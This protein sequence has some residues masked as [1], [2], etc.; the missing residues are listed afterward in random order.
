MKNSKRLYSILPI[1]LIIIMVPYFWQVVYAQG[2]QGAI[3]YPID[4]FSMG[5]GASVVPQSISETSST[6]VEGDLSPI[7]SA[8][9][10][11][12][13]SNQDLSTGNVYISSYTVIDALGSE[14]QN[15]YPEDTIWIAVTVVDERRSQNEI[16]AI[17]GENIGNYVQSRIVNGAFSSVVPGNIT[18]KLRAPVNGKLSFT[19]IFQDTVYRGGAPVFKFDIIQ[20]DGSNQSS[21]PTVTLE[22]PIAQ[23]NDVENE[24]GTIV[25]RSITASTATVKNGDSFT[26]TSTISNTGGSVVKDLAATVSSDSAFALQTT[27]AIKYIGDFANGT[28]ETLVF[29]FD[30]V[31]GTES[32]IYSIE[33]SF[34]GTSEGSALSC[35]QSIDIHVVA[36]ERFSITDITAPD[37]LMVGQEDFVS[38]TVVNMGKSAIYNVTVTMFAENTSNT[39]QTKYIGNIESGTENK[40]EF[41]IVP[42]EAGAFKGEFTVTYENNEGQEESI[43]ETVSMTV[44][45]AATAGAQDYANMVPEASED[46]NEINVWMVVSIVLIIVLI[47]VVLLQ[48]VHYR[49]R[50]L[51]ILLEEDD[52]G[53]DSIR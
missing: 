36:E 51:K 2:Y 29:A 21:L 15:V 4:I 13:T 17:T 43:V 41:S 39:E 31:S 5:G 25:S 53:S 46:A 9:S 11:S 10:S 33:I 24:L 42:I 7:S 27:S 34:S 28:N 38:I 40:I 6:P 52:E 23:C 20:L 35:T 50:E 19:I 47:S 3:E 49:K 26:V 32:G 16:A 22:Q 44:Q 48:R 8:T 1:A 12:A 30:V 14:I 37:Y 45:A 18:Y